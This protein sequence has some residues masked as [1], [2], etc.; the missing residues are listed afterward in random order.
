MI[1]NHFLITYSGNKLFLKI[2]LMSFQLLFVKCFNRQLKKMKNTLWKLLHYTLVL[3]TLQN[4][5]RK[6]FSYLSSQIGFCSWKQ[7]KDYFKTYSQKL[8]F[9][10]SKPFH[11]VPSC[12]LNQSPLLLFR[13]FKCRISNASSIPF[14]T[15]ALF[16]MKVFPNPKDF[17]FCFFILFFFFQKPSNR[18]NESRLPIW[19]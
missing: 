19:N 17:F 1:E 12:L 10:W 11:L 16:R 13:W 8:F 14:E 6:L 18:L 9:W 7:F 2:N 5:L 15:V 4:K 3:N